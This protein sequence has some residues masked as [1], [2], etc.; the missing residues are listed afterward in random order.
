[1][2][3]EPVVQKNRD[4]VLAANT[5]GNSILLGGIA[6]QSAQE[7][8]RSAYCVQLSYKLRLVLQSSRTLLCAATLGGGGGGAEGELE[9][10]GL[11]SQMV[12]LL[13]GVLAQ[14]GWMEEGLECGLVLETLRMV[15]PLSDAQYV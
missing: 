3:S 15:T 13:K 5:A 4:K 6:G 7:F 8:R 11:Q 9:E 12:A 10:K 1:M 2:S 14:Q